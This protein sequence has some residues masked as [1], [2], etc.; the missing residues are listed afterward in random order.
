MVEHVRC[1]R[2]INLHILY[3]KNVCRIFSTIKVIY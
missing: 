2:N 1:V 3:G